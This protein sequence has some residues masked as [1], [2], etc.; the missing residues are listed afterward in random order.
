MGIPDLRRFEN[1]ISLF[2]CLIVCRMLSK[3]VIAIR[4]EIIT[5]L[6]RT[7]KGLRFTGDCDF[8]IVSPLIT[9]LEGFNLDNEFS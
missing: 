8:T 9:F 5:N 6:G 4:N 2:V 7:H 3:I 1:F